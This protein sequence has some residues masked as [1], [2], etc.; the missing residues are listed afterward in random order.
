MMILCLE[1][2]VSIKKSPYLTPD[3]K[4][5]VLE[6]PQAIELEVWSTASD[7]VNVEVTR[8]SD[9]SISF[10][11]STESVLTTNTANGLEISFGS[12]RI[13][14]PKR[15]YS[16]LQVAAE[17]AR[18]SHWGIN[19]PLSEAEKEKALNSSDSGV[20]GSGHVAPPGKI[21]IA[22]VYADDPNGAN[23]GGALMSVKANMNG[24][25]VASKVKVGD[26]VKKGDA[27]AVLEAMKMETILRSPING[28]VRSVNVKEGQSIQQG[29]LVAQVEEQSEDVKQEK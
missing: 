10:S 1:L 2:F 6:L 4:N 8:L 18:P 13:L 5:A 16:A 11:N 25:V 21:V 20:A 23:A 3:E 19:G 28:I 9:D 12:D 27:I 7:R 26:V 17:T 29:M 15:N 14:V 24:K 22:Y